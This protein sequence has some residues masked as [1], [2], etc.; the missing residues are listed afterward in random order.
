[1]GSRPG[2]IAGYFE[3][4]KSDARIA[5]FDQWLIVLMP[6]VTTINASQEESSKQFSHGGRL[7]K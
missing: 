2:V 6:A 4:A 1:M 3:W 5:G 7:V